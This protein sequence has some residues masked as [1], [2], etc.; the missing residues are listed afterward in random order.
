MPD[1]RQLTRFTLLTTLTGLVAIF[2]AA[3][4]LPQW[5]G[6]IFL[7][8]AA[9]VVVGAALRYFPR[10]QVAALSK[11]ATPK[12]LFNSENEDRRTLIQILGALGLCAT[13]Y[14]TAQGLLVTQQG[15][16]VTQATAEKNL[17][18]AE[19]ALRVSREGEITSRFIQ[20]TQNLGS[21]KQELRLGA[22]YALESVAKDSPQDHW[23]V[24]EILTAFLRQHAP[25]RER[26]ESPLRKALREQIEQAYN[27]GEKPATTPTP[28]V[29]TPAPDI[30]QIEIAAV[31]T[32]IARRNW[33]NETGK[34]Q[35]LDL[36][37]TNLANADLR[38]AHLDGANFAGD[39]L[40][41]AYFIGATLRKANFDRADLSE[42]CFVDANMENAVLGDTLS[43]RSYF[44]RAN[45]K[46]AT[47][48]AAKLEGAMLAGANLEEVDFGAAD[49]KDVYFQDAD[50]SKS[51]ITWEQIKATGY[52]DTKAKVPAE[53]EPLWRAEVAARK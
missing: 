24:M 25:Y 27:N 38:N 30:S 47:F 32:V 40:E 12:E 33:A 15:Q 42:A 43:V 8:P 21:D 37:S 18:I 3:W 35:Y 5:R 49:L 50:L 48:A 31:L 36:R 23:Q 29:V 46:G 10:W 53:L 41:K 9:A 16:Q 20:A 2:T 7:L 19:Q 17:Q 52:L 4:L 6:A 11:V 34:D 14:F 44:A 13:I 39:N 22:I 1:R 28:Q 45:L 51:K 26:E